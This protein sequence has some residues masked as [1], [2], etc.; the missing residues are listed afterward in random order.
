VAGHASKGKNPII[1]AVLNLIFGLGYVYLGTKKVLGV[2]TIVFVLLVLVID[3]VLGVFTA[4][5]ASLLFGILLAVDGWQKA[6]G[7]KG[8]V[9]TEY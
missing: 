2:P 4:G 5:L 7:G 6:K 1:A 8:Y 3:L 9:S